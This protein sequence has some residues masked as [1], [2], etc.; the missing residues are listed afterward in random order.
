MGVAM[1]DDFDRACAILFD[2]EHEGGFADRSYADDPG[3][4]TMYGISE[5]AHPEAWRDG[6]PSREKA[7]AIAKAAYW[8]AIRGDDLPWPLNFLA[9][10]T[11]FMSGAGRAAKDLQVACGV[12]PDGVIGPQTI[13]AAN[14]VASDRKRL[15][16]FIS[17]RIVWLS[18]LANWSANRGGWVNRCVLNAMIVA[19]AVGG[20]AADAS[21]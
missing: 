13:A 5:R 19:D 17:S 9:M 8:D 2:A 7:R 16:R 12:T 1:S 20:S 15:A 21:A 18:T 14:R 3:G 4:R 6:P 10:E 11:A